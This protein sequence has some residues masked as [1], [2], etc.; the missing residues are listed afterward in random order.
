MLSSSC[1]CYQI[2]NCHRYHFGH[3]LLCYLSC[4]QM[5]NKSTSGDYWLVIDFSLALL[6]CL[7][8]VEQ[9]CCQPQIDKAATMK[10]IISILWYCFTTVLLLFYYCFCFTTV[11]LLFYYCFTTVLLS[12]HCEAQMVSKID[13]IVEAKIKKGVI[14]V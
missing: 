7:V 3:T 1:R 4:T 11:L 13:K 12:I 8:L 14:R 2:C 6:A 10:C 9:I 5:F